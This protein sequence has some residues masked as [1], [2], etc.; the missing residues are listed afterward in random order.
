MEDGKSLRVIIVKALE[1][2]EEDLDKDPT[3]RELICTSNHDQV[4]DILSYSKILKTSEDQHD[5]DTVE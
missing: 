2:H 5:E 3:Q 1:A 4:E